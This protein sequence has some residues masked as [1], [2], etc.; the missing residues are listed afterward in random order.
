MLI[1]SKTSMTRTPMTCLPWLIRTRFFWVPR[2]F[3]NNSRKQIFKAILGT[4]CAFYHECRL[5]VLIRI[6]SLKRFLWVHSTY[7]LFIDRKD[8]PK[9]FSFACWPDTTI[10]PQ[11][12]ELPMSRTN[13]DGP[14]DVRVIEVRLYISVKFD[15]GTNKICFLL[16]WTLFCLP[17]KKD[18]L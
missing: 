13:F 6:A 7:Y 14:E 12:L 16:L 15:T 8:N 11:W 2:K 1:Y 17:S 4:F 5:G 9:L 18:L 3:S 10:N